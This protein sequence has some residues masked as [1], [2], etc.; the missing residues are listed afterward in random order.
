MAF[1]G[2]RPEVHLRLEGHLRP[3]GHLGAEGQGFSA[4]D[5]AHVD[6]ERPVCDEVFADTQA[7]GPACHLREAGKSQ[8]RHDLPQLASDENHKA[9]HVLGFPLK[10]PAELFVLGGN[11]H[12]AGV[13]GT[14]AHHHTAHTDQGCRG[15]AEF[16]RSQEGGDGHIT[17]AHQFSV[18]LQDHPAAQA[19]FH[20]ASVGFR[21]AKFPGQARIVDRASGCRTGASVVAGDQ[22]DLGTCLGDARGDGTYAGL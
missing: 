18:C 17:A 15:E 3:K 22:D 19:V 9:D 12:R 11:A 10:A 16:L 8:L 21:Q 7:V 6:A 1:S 20:Q 14:D 2:L 13:L 4:Q 5:G